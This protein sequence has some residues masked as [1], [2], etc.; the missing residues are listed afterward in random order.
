LRGRGVGLV[1]CG[2]NIDPG[3]FGGYLGGEPPG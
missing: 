2:T 1:V 3:T